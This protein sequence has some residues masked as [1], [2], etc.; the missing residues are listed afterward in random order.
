MRLFLLHF[1]TYV[2]GLRPLSDVHR[3]QTLTYKVGPRAERVNH[4]PDQSLT[5]PPPQL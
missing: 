1:N 4:A 2:M 3:R 5:P